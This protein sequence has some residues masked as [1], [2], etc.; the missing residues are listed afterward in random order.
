MQSTNHPTAPISCCPMSHVCLRSHCTCWVS[1]TG[2]RLSSTEHVVLFW[3][4][5]EPR[6]NKPEVDR[7]AVLSTAKL[8]SCAVQSNMHTTQHSA[9]EQTM[10]ARMQQV[11][12]PVLHYAAGHLGHG[13]SQN[14]HQ[15]LNNGGCEGLQLF[16]TALYCQLT[17]R[18]V[19]KMKPPQCHSSKNTLNAGMLQL[20][21]PDPRAYIARCKL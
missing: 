2:L 12:R 3:Q 10:G 6:A 19:N 21:P 20:P 18:Q 9:D 1:E 13:S 14:G 17:Y 4:K 7:Q 11:V 8:Q 5:S 16:W 15:A